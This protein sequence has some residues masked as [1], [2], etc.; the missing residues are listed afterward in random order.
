[1]TSRLKK[2]L[3]MLP[4]LY[5]GGAQAQTSMT[6]KQPVRIRFE[7]RIAGKLFAC[8]NRYEGV[9]SKAST[10]TPVDLRFFISNAELLSADGSST[11]VTL[12]QDGIWQ[13]KSLSLI[14]LEDGTG[15]C[16][17]GNS[18]THAFVSGA[19]SPGAYVGVRFTLGVPFELDHIESSAAPSPLNMTAMLWNWQ[20]GYKFLRAEVAVVP[21][22]TTKAAKPVATKK[23]KPQTMGRQPGVS[24]FPVHL[25]STGC[26][27]PNPVAAP[28]RECVHPNRLVITLPVFDAAKDVV[29]FDLGKLLARSSLS[30]NS[31]HTS[32]GCMSFENDPDCVPIMQALGLP[33]GDSPAREQAVFYRRAEE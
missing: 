21:T 11:P 1:M 19:I 17:N 10:V 33:Y 24:G 30:A 13:Y 5:V 32:P 22:A 28:E 20:N 2:I 16:R 7:S 14:D 9:G 23:P 3:L 12:E 25:G 18:A 6:E 4:L 15:D 27:G 29:V 8:G 31:Q 26:G